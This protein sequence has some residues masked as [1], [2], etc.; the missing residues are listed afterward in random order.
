MIHTLQERGQSRFW[1]YLWRL[2]DVLS[3]E[4]NQTTRFADVCRPHGNG[5]SK[6][7]K[8]T[9]ARSLDNHFLN[10]RNIVVFVSYII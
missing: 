5:P 3:R 7:Q 4:R 1:Y 2:G 6:K 10:I 9:S 8:K